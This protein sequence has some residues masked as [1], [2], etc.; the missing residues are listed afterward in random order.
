MKTMQGEPVALVTGGSSGFGLLT[1]VE[2][3]RRGFAVIA[4]IRRMEAQAGLMDAAAEAGVQGKIVAVRLDVTDP[5]GV[6]DAAA[7]IRQAVRLGWTCWSTMPERPT[8]VSSRRCLPRFGRNRWIR[9][10]TA[11][12]G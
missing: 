4:G 7:Y 3:A 1:A 10:F 5:A 6:A 11:W 8:E 9:T 2:L 12:C